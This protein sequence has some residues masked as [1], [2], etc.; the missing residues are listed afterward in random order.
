[1]VAR[2]KRRP[3]ATVT[4]IAVAAAAAAAV[5]LWSPHNRPGSASSSQAGDHSGSPSEPWSV[6]NHRLF[7]GMTMKQVERIAGGRPAGVRG[8]CWI[9]RPKVGAYNGLPSRRV[10]GLWLGQPG[11]D[12]ARTADAIELC[13]YGGVLNE[14]YIHTDTLLGWEWVSTTL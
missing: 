9:Y 14:E 13:F 1:M 8:R 7:F 12:A 11:S 2:N 10:G 4:V 5:L 3:A 6:T